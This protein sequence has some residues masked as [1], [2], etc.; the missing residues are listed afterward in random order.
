MFSCCASKSLVGRDARRLNDRIDKE[1]L[2]NAKEIE[3]TLKLLLLG[4][5]ESGKST[6]TK[7][8]KIIHGPETVTAMM[9]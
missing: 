1:L 6:L 8:M 2:A 7:Q 4:V 9:N 3:T 5:G